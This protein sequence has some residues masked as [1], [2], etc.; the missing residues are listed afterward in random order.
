MWY[1]WYLSGCSPIYS[2]FPNRFSTASG[3]S[4]CPLHSKMKPIFPLPKSPTTIITNGL[5]WSDDAD[6]VTSLGIEF[7]IS[8]AAA[9]LASAG[10][11]RIGT[12]KV[13][14][15]CLHENGWLDFQFHGPSRFFYT[16]DFIMKPTDC[17]VLIDKMWWKIKL[18]NPIFQ[19]CQL[20]STPRIIDLGS[21]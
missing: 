2:Y 10:L 9:L 19:V 12:V 13:A 15:S 8:A 5:R 14:V 1:Q 6:M 3:R 21:R 17:M 11:S 18:P 7:A 20:H 16:W 4:W